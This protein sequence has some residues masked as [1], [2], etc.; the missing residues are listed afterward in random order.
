MKGCCLSKVSIQGV[1]ILSSPFLCQ[2]KMVYAFISRTILQ[3]VKVCVS[4][5]KVTRTVVAIL[6]G[7]TNL[8]AEEQV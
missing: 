7:S 3:N 8:T 1:I 6:H 4:G 2:R 5:K